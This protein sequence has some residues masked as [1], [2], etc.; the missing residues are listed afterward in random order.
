MY[1][2]RNDQNL[3]GGALYRDMLM[4]K[5]TVQ[6]SHHWVGFRVSLLIMKLFTGS[7]SA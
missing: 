1:R 4:L 7:S 5:F 2:P 6:L 3:S